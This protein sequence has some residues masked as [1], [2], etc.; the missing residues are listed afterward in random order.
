M[1]SMAPVVPMSLV[2][3]AADDVKAGGGFEPTVSLVR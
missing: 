1:A 2:E 3:L